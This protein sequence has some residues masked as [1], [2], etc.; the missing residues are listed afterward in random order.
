MSPGCCWNDS[1]SADSH[2]KLT[3]VCD[4]SRLRPLRSSRGSSEKIYR[5]WAKTT[6][7]RETMHIPST[8]S[9][10]ERALEKN[11]NW[12]Q[13]THRSGV[14]GRNL[15]GPGA[16]STINGWLLQGPTPGEELEQGHQSLHEP[17]QP[18]H[19]W[20]Q[21]ESLNSNTKIVWK[22]NDGE[23]ENLKFFSELQI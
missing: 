4:A 10:V 13:S 14:K 23:K 8:M 1:Q 9:P 5:E 2:W 11:S 22:L 12:A 15:T 7:P 17:A 6:V 3:A 19:W 18:P 16:S 21:M 20:K